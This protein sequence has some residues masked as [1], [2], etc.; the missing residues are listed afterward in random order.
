VISFERNELSA[1]SPSSNCLILIIHYRF[2]LAPSIMNP[3]GAVWTVVKLFLRVYIIDELLT[4]EEV[5][6]RRFAENYFLQ[7]VLQKCFVVRRRG[8]DQAF[9]PVVSALF[10]QRIRV[11]RPWHGPAYRTTLPG[12]ANVPSNLGCC[13]IATRYRG[14]AGARM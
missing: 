7:I 8:P 6:E 9:E 14:S 3:I 13:C 11:R 4:P 5:E 1:R 10:P 12:T 2:F